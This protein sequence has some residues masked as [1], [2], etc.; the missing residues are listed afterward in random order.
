LTVSIPLIAS[1]W[2]DWY[3]P[4]ASSRL[5]KTGRRRVR[6]NRISPAYSGAVAR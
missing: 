5:S 2:R 3:F 1:I 6:E 4:Y